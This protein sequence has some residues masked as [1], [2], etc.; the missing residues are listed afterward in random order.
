MFLIILLSG[1]SDNT[2][3]EPIYTITEAQFSTELQ[4]ID[5]LQL[6][7]TSDPDF[8]FSEA[9]GSINGILSTAGDKFES[10]LE[11]NNST[12]S[13]KD[14]MS[15]MVSQLVSD[16][17]NVVFKAG[18]YFYA[19]IEYK[20]VTIGNTIVQIPSENSFF[21]FGLAVLFTPSELK[22]EFTETLTNWITFFEKGLPLS[23][24][25][26]PVDPWYVIEIYVQDSGIDF[27]LLDNDIL[28]LVYPTTGDRQST[29]DI[30]NL[31]SLPVEYNVQFSNSTS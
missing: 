7:S 27:P 13:M 17:I 30:G 25:P 20:E 19:G 23:T 31:P 10:I 11:S 6:L 14:F 12:L 15:D 24:F 8:D 9:W 28:I 26:P 3:L 5:G 4:S 18:F 1:C 22:E 16:A 21:Y 2:Y 29:V